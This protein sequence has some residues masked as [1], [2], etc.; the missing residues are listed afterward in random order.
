MPSIVQLRPDEEMLFEGDITLRKSTFDAINGAGAV[1]TQRFCFKSS[2]NDM[3]FN[4]QEI[5]RIEEQGKGL[6]KKLVL[7]LINGSS[8]NLQAMNARGL[9]T[10]L[11]VLT[12]QESEANNLLAEP[13][14]NTVR[15]GT[16][17]LAAFSPLIA[18][19][20]FIVLYMLYFTIF[21][22][23]DPDNVRTFTKLKLWVMELAVIW[24]FVE[25]DY[26][27][28][29]RQGFNLKKMGLDSPSWKF[30]L[31]LFKRAKTFGHTMGYAV[32]WSILFA[33]EVIISLNDLVA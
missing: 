28:L 16:A 8:V 19:L 25:F 13:D 4:K 30:P 7:H 5:A 12:G 31:Y 6:G 15:N 9:K 3:A 33:I 32:T 10:A 18:M 17:W 21:S 2:S 14:K 1:T 23:S 27:W 26:L 24:G 22:N 11:S 29:Q 20:I